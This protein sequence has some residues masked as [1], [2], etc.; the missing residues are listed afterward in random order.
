MVRVVLAAHPA[1]PTARPFRHTARARRLHISPRPS[2][3]PGER[4]SRRV[5]AGQ[6]ACV[7]GYSGAARNVAIATASGR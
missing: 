5:R 3:R 1:R 4:L 7:R 6:S 2:T